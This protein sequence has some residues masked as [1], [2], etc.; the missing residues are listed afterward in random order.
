MSTPQSMVKQA[1]NLRKQLEVHNYHYYVLD[2]PIIADQEYDQLLTQLI[3]LEQQYPDL[4]T[5]D[6]PTQRVGAAPLSVFQS[7]PHLQRMYSLA[8]AFTEEAIQAFDKR[9]RDKLACSTEMEYVCEPKLDGLAVNCIY[10]QGL[11][12][13][14]MTRG[15]GTVGEDITQNVRTIGGVPLRLRTR[16]PP[17]RVEVRGEVFMSKQG[18]ERLNAQALEVGDKPFANPRNAA[19]GSLR[20]LDSTITARRPLHIYGYGLG[21]FEGGAMPASQMEI[22]Q[23]LQTW[24]FPVNGETQLAQGIAQCYQYYQALAVRREQLAYE[25]DGVVYKV[26]DCSWQQRLGY[27]ARAPRWALAHK[28]PARE[29]TT[30][31]TQVDFQ[32]GRT[33]VLTPVARLVPVAIGGVMVANATLHNM[34]EINRKDIRIGDWVIVRRAGDVIPEVIKPIMEKRGPDTLA[35]RLPD[36]CPACHAAIVKHPGLVAVHC[37]AGLACKAQL[38]AAIKHFVS[39]KALDIHGL[40]D[41]IV[42]QLI[43]SG[44]V[45]N[46]A[47]IY[48][49][50]YEQL[51]ALDRFAEKSAQ[52]LIDSIQAKQHVPFARFLY[53]L[54]ISG[55]G[56]M[57]AQKLAEH[58]LTM[59]ALMAADKEA[60]MAID[61]V[62]PIVAEEIVDFFKDKSNQRSLQQLFTLGV[63][64]APPSQ[65]K[66]GTALAGLTFVITGS[67]QHYTREQIKLLLNTHGANVTSAVS[68]NTDYLLVGTSPGSK[69]D[70]AK[71][72]GVKIL[73]ESELDILLNK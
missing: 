55:V 61:D 44:L 41:K 12:V 18:F 19:A 16:H 40:G 10:E 72:L 53:A 26:N 36:S 52:K 45:S 5:I 34:E 42:S 29:A 59:T 62:G 66:P 11:L 58:F 73:K 67:L 54:G 1:D 9:V 56:E 69:Y 15:D 2:D 23:L 50:S 39:R 14:A 25:I 51:L 24:G 20:Q 4:K 3:A 49:L 13:R 70:N 38:K 17:D 37:V 22:L 7:V 30:Q 46:V 65:S 33:G 63:Q 6:S 31:L 21:V 47:D 27:V 60:L 48:Q 64:I 68:K 8:N 28:Y 43:A 35:I 32:V 57:T 71:K